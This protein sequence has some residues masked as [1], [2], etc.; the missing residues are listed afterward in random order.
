MNPVTRPYLGSSS[1]RALM[2]LAAAAAVAVTMS[3]PEGIQAQTFSSGSDGSD[4]ALTLAANLGTV[5]FD[6]GDQTRWGRVLDADGDGVYN[7]TTIT[8]GSATD[9]KFWGDSL[10]RPIYWLA[11]GDVTIAGTLDL[12]GEGQAFNFSDLNI[13][14]KVTRPG[15]GGFAGGAGGNLNAATPPTPGEGPGGGAGGVSCVASGV[16]YL[17]GKGGVFSGNHYLIPLI[18]GSGGEGG[19]FPNTSGPFVAG[20]AG[21]GAILIASSTSVTVSPGGRITAVGGNSGWGNSSGGE[22]VGGGGSGGAIRLAAPVLSG[23]GHLDVR[24]GSSYQTGG[25]PGWVRL[26]SYSGGT[27]L[28]LDAGASLATRG[29]PLNAASLRP[30]SAVRVVSVAGVAVRSSPQGSFSV[31][32]VTI[33]SGGLVPV[34]IEATGIPPGTTVTL[35]VFPQSP[36]DNTVINLPPVQTTLSGTLSLSTATVSFAF[37]YGFSRGV[38][39]ATWTQ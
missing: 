25:G 23:S 11:S 10:N 17:C 33:S 6:P 20:G 27:S 13:R 34:S 19:Q 29:S 14:R 24:G 30:A 28:V 26:E 22:A 16:T 2:S 5:V 37:P 4:G 3:P 12:N 21:G 38:L 31:P 7:F 32:D 15:A 1:L 9:L 39:H 36:A 35:R 18:G 8:V